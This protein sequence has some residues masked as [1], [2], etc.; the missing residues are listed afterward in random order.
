MLIMDKMLLP[1]NYQTQNGQNVVTT[2][3]PNP[4]STALPPKSP[5][6]GTAQPTARDDALICYYHPR[7]ADK[8]RLC[9]DPC[10]FALNC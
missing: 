7:F 1:Q 3:L 10:A 5:E 6:T 2:K 8:A 9:R 4:H